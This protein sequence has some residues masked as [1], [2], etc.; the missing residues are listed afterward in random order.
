VS[1]NSGFCSCISNE[2]ASFKVLVSQIGAVLGLKYR[3]IFA[4]KI[5]RASTRAH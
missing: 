5:E 4:S 1:P 2:A 3:N